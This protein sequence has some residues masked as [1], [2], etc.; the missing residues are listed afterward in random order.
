MTRGDL[1]SLAGNCGH[2]HRQISVR[3]VVQAFHNTEEKIV[4]NPWDII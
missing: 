1:R 3:L 2:H 4:V